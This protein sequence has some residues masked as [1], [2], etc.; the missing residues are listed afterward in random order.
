MFQSC[1]R[2]VCGSWPVRELKYL[3]DNLQ[4]SGNLPNKQEEAESVQSDVGISS[5][6]V[7]LLHAWNKSGS[8]GPKC[9]NTC[10]CPQVRT[11]KEP[12]CPRISVQAALYAEGNASCQKEGP[13]HEVLVSEFS[14]NQLF[15]PLQPKKKKKRTQLVMICAICC[16][17]TP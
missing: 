7:S 12:S 6:L 9:G 17:A 1:K 2:K 16:C 5:C 11:W 8:D 4:S 10:S 3:I 14:F 13:P 15:P